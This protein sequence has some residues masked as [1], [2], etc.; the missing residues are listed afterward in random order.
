MRRQQCQTDYKQTVIN[1][2]RL[3]CWRKIFII[4]IGARFLRLLKCERPS[5]SVHRRTIWNRSIAYGETIGYRRRMAIRIAKNDSVQANWLKLGKMLRF[6]FPPWFSLSRARL[7]GAVRKPLRSVKICK[8]ADIADSC[9]SYDDR[10][11]A[12]SV[13]GIMKKSR[14]VGSRRYKPCTTQRA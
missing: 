8:F 9:A 14:S 5:R 1:E 7:D 13:R 4:V 2:R 3:P 6:I 11:V 12:K 10:A